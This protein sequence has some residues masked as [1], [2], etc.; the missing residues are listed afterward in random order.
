MS[1]RFL[2]VRSRE[3]WDL[4]VPAF[5]EDEA[6]GKAG[7]LTG[8]EIVKACVDQLPNKVHGSKN[9]NNCNEYIP[10]FDVVGLKVG[11][12]VSDQ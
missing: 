7:I 5:G 1:R 9:H 3:A 6:G 2:N 12:P 11:C 10:L 8:R 4:E